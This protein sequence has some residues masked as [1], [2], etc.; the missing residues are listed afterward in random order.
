MK[1]YS[2]CHG[3]RVALEHMIRLQRPPVNSQRMPARTSAIAA[4]AERVGQLIPVIR[5]QL[6][7]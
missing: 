3:L 5:R 4:A 2:W 6:F 7:P 1:A